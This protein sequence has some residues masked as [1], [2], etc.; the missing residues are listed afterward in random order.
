VVSGLPVVR[1][2]KVGE[3]VVDPDIMIKVQVLADIPASER[4]KVQ[5]LNVST[6]YFTAMAERMKAQKG[7]DF[8]VCDLELPA[9]VR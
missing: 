1:A 8:S 2:L 4:P 6:A 5:V 3:P 9:Q 7:A